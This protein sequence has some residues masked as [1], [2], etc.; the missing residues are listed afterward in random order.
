MLHRFE[1]MTQKELNAKVA[2]LR[3]GQVVQI[4]DDYFQAVR[5]PD[6]WQVRACEACDLGSVCR[7][8]VAEVCTEL[9]H[10]LYT[11]WYLKLAHD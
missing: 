1:D 11:K 2:L 4:E 9:D 6:D 3:D 8:D 7:G 10:P 5:L